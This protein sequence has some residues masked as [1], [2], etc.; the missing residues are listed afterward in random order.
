MAADL[1]AYNA[2]LKEIWTQDRLEQQFYEGTPL[3]DRLTKTDR[4]NIGEYAVT[5]IQLSRTGGYSVVPASGSTSLNAATQVGMNQAQWKYTHHH[6]LVKVEGSAIDQ[7]SGKEL[8][9]A[10]AVDTELASAT[11]EIRKQITRQAFGA[12]DA[13]IAKCTTSSS[14]QAVL[15]L[16]P[17]D[18]GYDA[19]VRR[20][21]H[22]NLTVDIGTTANET[23]VNA[24]MVISSVTKSSSAPA[25]TLT[26]NL[27]NAAST[28]H[29]VSIANARAGTTSNEMNG[30]RNI[31]AA[32][33]ALGGIDP[34]S[35]PDWAAAAVDSTS[36]ALSL[37]AMYQKQREVQM[38][39][40]DSFDWIVTSYKQEENF[41]KLLQD[42]IRYAGDRELG[43]GNKNGTNFAGAE[44]FCQ[45]DCPDRSMFFL[46]SKALFIVTA[47]K[48]YWQNEIA[49]GKPLEWL[50]QTTAFGG[51]LTYRI[52]L[53]TNRRNAHAALTN[54]T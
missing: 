47:G 33:G 16:D 39:T 12:G 25:I 49:G 52:N 35:Y 2:A 13:L 23:A 51:L 46:T 22:P 27:S 31:V 21:L 20:W 24:D 34:A 14:G 9:V 45:V 10:N 4:Y 30:L 15:S 6:M 29:F 48:P 19:I 32:S 54:L 26:S 5:P 53:A 17:T 7:T 43:A 18:F 42:R 1:T 50:Q 38:E 44:L 40:G 28:S 37:A 41:Y 8:S 11:S 3:L 36:Q